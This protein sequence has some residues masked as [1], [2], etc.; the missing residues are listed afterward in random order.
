M[1][2]QAGPL[3]ARADPA[4]DLG[5]MFANSAT[6]YYRISTAHRCEIR[7][8]ILP[9]PIAEEL[10]SQ[11]HAAVVVLLQFLFQDLH[12][13]GQAGDARSEEH[14]SELQSLRHLVC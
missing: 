9:R 13:I 14:T 3:E 12:V 10:D 4:T 1:Y 11:A 2:G 5:R 7:A 6:E 8:D